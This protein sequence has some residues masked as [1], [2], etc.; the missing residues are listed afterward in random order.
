MIIAL[1]L[2]PVTN[3]ACFHSRHSSYITAPFDV[4]LT[5]YQSA[6]SRNWW[7]RPL[8]WQRLSNA[9]L[10]RETDATGCWKSI[11]MKLLVLRSI[12]RVFF[13]VM[14]TPSNIQLSIRTGKPIYLRHQI[15]MLHSW[16]SSVPFWLI[17]VAL[18]KGSIEVP[19]IM[20]ILQFLRH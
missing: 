5:R 13:Q 20:M 9:L 8:P 17:T 4:T 12:F 1:D 15:A 18:P 7:R 10:M 19:R 11:S 2:P 3:N 14:S 6:W 16:K